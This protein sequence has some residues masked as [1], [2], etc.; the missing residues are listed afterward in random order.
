[1]KKWEIGWW[2]LKD[3]M[4]KPRNRQDSELLGVEELVKYGGKH[5]MNSGILRVLVFVVG[6]FSSVAVT[7]CRSESDIDDAISEKILYDRQ[8]LYIKEWDGT[9]Q[10]GTAYDDTA[11]AV[12]VDGTGDNFDVLVAGSSQASADNRDIFLT[13][14][15]FS[16]DKKWSVDMKTTGDDVVH[17]LFDDGVGVLVA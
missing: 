10:F 13:K 8:G 9:R 2:E 14:Y 6:L 12:S 17:G 15:D 11:G 7:G 5:F 16:G 3:G 4:E 1:M